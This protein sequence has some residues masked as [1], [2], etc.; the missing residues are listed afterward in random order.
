MSAGGFVQRVHEP[1]QTTDRGLGLAA[2]LANICCEQT[3]HAWF[4]NSNLVRLSRRHSGPTCA[5][6]TNEIS[7][8]AWRKGR[9]EAA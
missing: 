5:G 6:R 2:P 9:I 4:V 8:K 7:Y 3:T 1:E